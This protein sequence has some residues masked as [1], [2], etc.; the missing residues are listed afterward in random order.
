MSVRAVLVVTFLSLAPQAAMSATAWIKQTSRPAIS[1]CGDV[2][3]PPFA[4]PLDAG[5]RS[6]PPAEARA[7]TPR[8]RGIGF[9]ILDL[10]SEACFV[11]DESYRLLDDVIDEVASRLSAHRGPARAQSA[12]ALDIATVTGEVM[13]ARG[14]G[15][16]VP[17]ETLG[18]ALAR[19][20]ETPSRLDMSLTATQAQ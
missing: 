16:Y 6:C 14:F 1:H 9:D 3:A 4:N 5:R 17:T 12:V 18:D 11:P 7:Y 13:A 20:T 10:E 15:L 8:H 2:Y 19:R